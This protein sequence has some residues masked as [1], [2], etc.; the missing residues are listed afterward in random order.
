VAV[1]EEEEKAW[2]A[3]PFGPSSAATASSGRTDGTG[4]TNTV[5][6]PR[7]RLTEA[8]LVRSRREGKSIG[9][10][11][12]VPA[13]GESSAPIPPPKLVRDPV[14]ARALDLLKG[15]SVIRPQ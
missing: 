11:N 4:G 7:R 5:S 2:I 1:R 8:D 9:Q 12:T 10:T 3:D 13:A 6:R 15:L 14:L